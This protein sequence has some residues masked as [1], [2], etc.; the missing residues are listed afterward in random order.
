MSVVRLVSWNINGASKLNKRLHISNF[1][2]KF[3]A[4]TL[5]ETYET[6]EALFLPE[7]YVRFAVAA[8]VTGGR[9]S[10]G[11]STL[12]KQDVGRNVKFVQLPPPVEWVVLVRWLAEGS[13]PVL[14]CNIYLPRHS[15]DFNVE[16]MRTLFS[17][18]KDV[19][20]SYPTDC[21]I[22]CGDWNADV[23]RTSSQ[24]IERLV[25]LIGHCF[26]SR[27]LIQF[28]F[29]WFFLITRSSSL[30]LFIP[31]M[32]TQINS[33]RLFIIFWSLRGSQRVDRLFKFLSF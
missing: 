3:D 29:F 9:P 23:Y 32:K 22:L 18:L 16:D 28:S 11:I 33:T 21:F 10:G 12:L 6:N 25:K 4:I 31:T 17:Y 19:R 24:T 5:Q 1:L 30:I 8:K 26:L 2:S 15:R 13:T 27:T 7:G 14:L 20:Q